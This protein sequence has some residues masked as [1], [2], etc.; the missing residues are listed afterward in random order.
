MYSEL[1]KEIVRAFRYMEKRGWNHGKA[2]N[3]SVFVR[4]KDHILVTPSGVSKVKLKPSDI[5]VVDLGGNVVDGAGKPTVEL[6]L[7]LAIYRAYRYVN[8]VVHAHGVFSTVLAVI[9]EPLPP[10]IEEIIVELGGEI[11]V[12]EYAPSGTL[13]LAQNV[14]KALEGRKA[15]ILANHGVITCGKNLEEAVELLGLVERL[16]QVYV[17]SRVLGK[18]HTLP[19]EVVNYWE[20]VFA[21]RLQRYQ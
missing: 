13:E 10:L 4:E 9:R 12:A 3:V 16:S 21:E 8:A 6:P 18:V 11:R 1:K 14:V 17:L 19:R 5:L 7:H 15:A 2:G 20:K